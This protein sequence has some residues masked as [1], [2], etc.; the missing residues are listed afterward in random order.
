[1]AKKMFNVNT[2]TK[3]GG[4]DKTISWTQKTSAIAYLKDTI[5]HMEEGKVT[6]LE[7]FYAEEPK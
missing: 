1:M 2:W 5:R 6:K 4:K 7:V 3:T